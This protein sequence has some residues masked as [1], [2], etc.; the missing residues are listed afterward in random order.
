MIIL[1]TALGSSGTSWSG[2]LQWDY[3]FHS[4]LWCRRGNTFLKPLVTTLLTNF[5]D[6]PRCF[7]FLQFSVLRLKHSLMFKLIDAIYLG[8]DPS[9]FV[10]GA[11]NEH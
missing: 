4:Y 3:T 1:H 10:F 2:S 8:S 6:A 9:D 5:Y 11:C 7:Q